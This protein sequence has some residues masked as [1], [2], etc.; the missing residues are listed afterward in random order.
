M[1]VEY[2]RPKS[3]TEALNLLSNQNILTLPLGGGTILNRPS[4]EIIG[5][6]DLQELNLGGYQ[7]HNQIIELG[8]TLTLQELV[9]TPDLPENLYKT[10]KLEAN[11]NIRQSATVAGVLVAADGRSPFATM[12]LA[13]DAILCCASLLPG[14]E[15]LRLGEVTPLGMK[16]LRG[17]L[18][19]KIKIPLNIRLGYEYV[20]R[21]PA[22]LPIVCV[23]IVRWPSGRT[24]LALGGFG[25]VPT[26][27]MDGPQAD[28][29][30]LAA[31]SAYSHASD[32]WASADYRSEIARILTRRCLEQFSNK[33]VPS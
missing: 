27:A 19:T 2:H 18:I 13:M 22:D 21:T 8:A 29:A 10:V 25:Q 7:I 33:S 24:R 3:I 30:D 14:E 6:V 23:A 12:M 28:G 32:Q 15:T 4:S 17:R 26:L 1:I 5:V 16:Q 11:Y 31:Q 9:D 20:A